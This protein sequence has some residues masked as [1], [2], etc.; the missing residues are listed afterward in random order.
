MDSTVSEDN[1]VPSDAGSDTAQGT[2]DSG[3]AIHARL[4]TIWALR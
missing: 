2:Q 4:L 1:L 3:P